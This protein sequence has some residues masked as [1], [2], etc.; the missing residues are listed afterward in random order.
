MVYY[1]SW[2]SSTSQISISRS[3]SKRSGTPALDF[4][5]LENLNINMVRYPEQITNILTLIIFMKFRDLLEG[6][7]DWSVDKYPFVT[8]GLQEIHKNHSR[9][10][11]CALKSKGN[12]PAIERLLIQPHFSSSLKTTF[13]FTCQRESPRLLPRRWDSD[14]FEIRRSSVT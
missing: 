2:T 5:E 13:T 1:S 11:E 12:V 3:A 14:A 7:L 9:R 6:Y 8:S 4:E 10:V